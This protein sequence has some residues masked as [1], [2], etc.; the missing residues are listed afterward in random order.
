MKK[1]N[2]TSN[3]GVHHLALVVDISN[4][5]IRR[6]IT[7]FELRCKICVPVSLGIDEISRLR[8]ELAIAHVQCIIIDV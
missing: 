8:M 5:G 7:P 4:I 2:L 3:R 6:E 1:K